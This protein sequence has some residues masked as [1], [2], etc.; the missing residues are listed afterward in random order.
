MLSNVIISFLCTVYTQ[1]LISYCSVELTSINFSVLA[2]V[3]QLV[4]LNVNLVKVEHL[5][6]VIH[7][8]SARNG[9]R[10]SKLSYIIY[11]VYA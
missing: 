9:Q 7:P 1:P 2:Q 4:I 11:P 3:H 10:M 6:S 5:A 8:T